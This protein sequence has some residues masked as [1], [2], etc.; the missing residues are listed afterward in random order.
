MVNFYVTFK[1]P[2]TEKKEFT[3]EYE[4][5]VNKLP[6]KSTIVV[7]PNDLVNQPFVDRMAHF[8]VLRALEKCVNKDSKIEDHIFYVKVKDFKKEAIDYSVKHQVLSEFTAFLCV[9]KQLVDGQYQE[10]KDKSVYEVRIQQP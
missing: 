10:F 8:K 7:D 3:F 2:L 5:D 6:F 1:G 4:D 9:G